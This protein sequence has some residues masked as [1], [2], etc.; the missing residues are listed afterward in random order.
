M[1]PETRKASDDQPLASSKLNRV[2]RLFDRQEATRSIQGLT[3]N[4]IVF[5]TQSRPAVN[6]ENEYHC[7]APSGKL[8]ARALTREVRA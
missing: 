8:M 4:M 2:A 1:N 6:Q 7:H 3:S 5:Y